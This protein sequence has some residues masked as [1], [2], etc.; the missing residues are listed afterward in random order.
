MSSEVSN[1]ACVLA[2]IG[3]YHGPWQNRNPLCATPSQNAIQSA[4][5]VAGFGP[6][7]VAEDMAF[8]NLISPVMPMASIGVQEFTRTVFLGSC[9]KGKFLL[10]LK[11]VTVAMSR[12][13]LTRSIFFLALTQLIRTI[14]RSK[15][16]LPEAN[17]RDGTN[18]PSGRFGKLW[19]LWRMF[20]RWRIVM[21]LRSKRSA[22]Y[23]GGRPGVIWDFAE[24]VDSFSP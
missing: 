16:A 24:R 11:S 6:V 10:I 15:G 7:N 8:I 14:C 5:T 2:S 23:D 3:P 9:S 4:K 1:I 20:T 21:E 13:A 19:N 18:L 17:G 12:F 22:T